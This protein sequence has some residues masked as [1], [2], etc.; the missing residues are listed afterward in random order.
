MRDPYT[1]SIRRGSANRIYSVDCLLPYDSGLRC[2]LEP[3]QRR[4]SVLLSRAG[5]MYACVG[6]RSQ[7][8]GLNEYEAKWLNPIQWLSERASE[9]GENHVGENRSV[10][11]TS[12][13][14]QLASNPHLPSAS[15]HYF[16]AQ[17]SLPANKKMM[18]YYVQVN[19]GEGTP[20]FI[21]LNGTPQQ[22]IYNLIIKL[23]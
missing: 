13:Y 7:K 5:W 18:C 12:I 17:T 9:R 3:P 15:L 4:W 19:D 22:T 20:F 16:Q 2:R 10:R 6:Q 14:I 11:S 1:E 21:L 8:G 23:C